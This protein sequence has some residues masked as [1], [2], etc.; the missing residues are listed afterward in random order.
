FLTP[1]TYDQIFTM[2]GTTMIF[3]VVMPVLIG[4]GVYLVPLMIGASDMAFPRLNALSFWLL[5]C[6]GFLL[7]VSFLA[8]GAPDAGWF[9]YAPLSLK[10]FSPHSGMDY[11]A[12]S[13]LLLGI[14]TI[15]SAVNFIVTIVTL[16]APGITIRR[17]PLFV[18][19]TLVNSVLILFA[20]PALNAALVMLLGD[21]LLH[22]RFFDARSEER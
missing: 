19:M 17:L 14:G 18:W 9:S 1:E 4:F 10:P 12:L 6:G 2:H 20:L 3:L 15:L 13:L 7:Y 22:A 16:R 21:R 8:G 11:W 5:V